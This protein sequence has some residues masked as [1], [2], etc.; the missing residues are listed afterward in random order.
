MNIA[1]V[2]SGNT[3]RSPMAKFLLKSMLKN[4]NIN[5]IQVF[6]FGLSCKNGENINQNTKN[7]LKAHKIKCGYHKTKKLTDKIIKKMDLVFVMTDEQMRILK[8]YGNVFSLSKYCNGQ[9]ILDPFNQG[10]QAYEHAF[11]QLKI[12]CKNIINQILNKRINW[13]LYKKIVLN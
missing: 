5:N 12:C 3:C 11:N 10:E 2:C 6:S 4:L 7:V 13:L 1:F 9:D 8:L